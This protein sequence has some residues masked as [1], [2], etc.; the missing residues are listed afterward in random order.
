MQ[1][2]LTE[3]TYIFVTFA[4]NQTLKTGMNRLMM[5]L[6]HFKWSAEFSNKFL[7][8]AIAIELESGFECPVNC[9]G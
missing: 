1:S 4:V 2:Y 8:S 6:T 5:F 7:N 3:T 9:V